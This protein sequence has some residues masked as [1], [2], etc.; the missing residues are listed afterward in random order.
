M[1]IEKLYEKINLGEDVDT[2]FKSAKGGL[3]KSLWESLSG[4]ANTSGGYIVLGVDELNDGSF[5]VGGIKNPKGMLKIFWD[6]HN[7]RQ[8]LSTPV[9]SESDVELLD[10]EGET[11]MVIY[12]PE[13]NRHQRPVFINGNPY[14]GTYKRNFEGDYRCSESEVR[15]MLRDASDDAQDFDIVENFSIDDID[16]ETLKAYRNRFRSRLSDHPYLALS[17]EEFLKKLG[18]YRVDRKSKA[19]GLTVAGLLMFGKESS[20]MEAFPH[21][22]LDYREKLT[23]DPEERWS[24]RIEQDGTW[25]GNLYNFYFRVYNRLVQDVEVPFALDNEGIRMGETHVH[26]AMREVLANTLIHADHKTSKSI[27]IL[28]EREAMTFRNPGRLRITISQLY[29]GGVTDPRNPYIQKIFQFLGLGE[30]AGSGFEK[31]LRAWKEQEWFRPL[32]YEKY[33]SDLTFVVLPML[34]MVPDHINEELVQVIG[35]DYHMTDELQRLILILAHQF[36]PISHSEI[37][38]YSTK[39]PRDVGEE[40]KKMVQKGWLVSEGRGRGTKYRLKRNISEGGQAGG[41]AVIQGGQAG[42]QAGLNPDITLPE[43]KILQSLQEGDKSSK[44]LKSVLSKD[45]VLSGAF[46]EKLIGLR[47]KG[48]IDYMI[49]DKPTSPNQK[50]RLTTLG[51]EILR[52][53]D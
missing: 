25:E 36:S 17:D 53:K 30:K 29:Q 35:S 40:L 32:V 5:A 2:E 10:V 24:Y 15:Q 33:D 26:E 49:P 51:Q 38:A 28:K 42:G 7:N 31:I 11:V 1:T 48:L 34:S 18:A 39:H 41:Q 43:W 3:P 9:C 20:I 37:S 8:K 23:K 12:V 45:T 46:K 14:M 47:D 21:F 6:T 52:N 44:E 4:F 50:Y 19:E 27:V 22:H 16:Q 13:T